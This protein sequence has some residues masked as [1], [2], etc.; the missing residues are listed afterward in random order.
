MKRLGLIGGTSW[1]STAEYYR[2]INQATNDHFG[3]STNPP[4]VLVNLNQAE[5]HRLQSSDQWDRIADML[6][7]AGERLVAAGAEAMM[8]CANTPHRVYDTVQSRM[9][10]PILHIA[11]ATAKAIQSANIETVGFIGTKYSMNLDFIA[12]PIAKQGI[13]VLV[14]E[15]MATREELHRII[16]QELSFGN[17]DPNSKQFVHDAIMSM[18][19][20]G[21]EGV[22]LGCTEFPLMFQN[23]EFE[24][25]QFDTV[26]IH[27]RA[28][29]DFVLG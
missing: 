21:A 24:F 8:F 13:E 17:I 28:A 7:D 11:E 20:R 16:H 26:K 10:I 19:E 3:D 15:G 14:P 6:T 27:A 5:V 23:D 1:H 18:A 25:P 4:L 29:V 9:S 2:L 22:V 12:G